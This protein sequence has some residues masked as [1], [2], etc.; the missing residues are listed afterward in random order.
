MKCEKEKEFLKFQVRRKVVNLY[1]SF[2]FILEDLQADGYNID[3]ETYQRV[4]KRVLDQGNDSIRE[5]EEYIENFQITL[6][7]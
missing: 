4:R 3:D 1:K 5:V 6:K 2:L 7:D